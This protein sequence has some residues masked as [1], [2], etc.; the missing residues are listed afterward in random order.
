MDR[1]SKKERFY[2]GLRIVLGVIFLVGRDPQTERNV[3]ALRERLLDTD[4]WSVCGSEDNWRVRHK[5]DHIEVGPWCVAEP[6]YMR[7]PFRWRTVIK[8]YCKKVYA[9]RDERRMDFLY[10]VLSGKYCYQVD[11]TDFSTQTRDEIHNW[12]ETEFPDA[13]I[14]GQY[15]EGRKDKWLYIADESMAVAFKLRF[16]GSR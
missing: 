7:I 15:T 1:L 3:T 11:L 14:E 5:T 8:H 9:L 12:L 4:A 10:D 13:K 6:E 2:H 16:E